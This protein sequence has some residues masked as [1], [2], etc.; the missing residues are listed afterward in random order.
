MTRVRA[1]GLA[2]ATAGGLLLAVCLVLIFFY[3]SLTGTG[4]TKAHHVAGWASPPLWALPCW[5]PACGSWATAGRTTD[6]A[7]P[8]SH[9]CRRRCHRRDDQRCDGPQGGARGP[10]QGR[11][12]QGCAAGG[13]HARHDL[14]EELDPH[15]RLLRHGDPPARRHLAHPR[16][17]HDPARPWRDDRGHRARARAHGRRDHDPHR[18]SRQD[19]G[20]GE[21]CRCAGHQ[22]PH[23]LLASLPDRCGPA[24]RGRAWPCAAGQQVGLDGRRQQRADLDHGGG[25]PHAFRRGRCLPAG[26][27]ARG[28][29]HRA[30]A[31]AGRASS[32]IR[33]RRRRAPMSSSPI[34]GSRWARPAARRSSRR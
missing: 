18:R 4:L 19:R 32:P 22:R 15:P 13:A 5:H 23:R 21:I 2:L 30:R 12:G 17:R 9:R 11:G 10:A 33:A 7:F 24:D 27:P 26:L 34:P 8:Q 14:R 29:S 25:R 20:N 3:P 16:R 31:E 1:I 28:R 6:A